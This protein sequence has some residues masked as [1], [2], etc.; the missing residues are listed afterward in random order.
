MTIDDM[1]FWIEI[2]KLISTIATPII[3]LIIG[4]SFLHIT[5]NIKATVIKESDFH[6]KWAEQF[7]EC[8]QEFMKILERDLALLNAI[9]GD[10]NNP[11]NSKDIQEDWGKEIYRLHPSIFELRFRIRRCIVFA[12]NTGNAV[13]NAANDCI[14][15]L[16]NLFATKR[17]NIDEIMDKMNEFNV[18]SHKAHSEMLGLD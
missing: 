4:I 1:K 18:A 15:L 11:N 17:G 6:K 9:S 8:C 10:L 13:T 12:P 2:V 7:F 5:E 16:N 3:V 14:G